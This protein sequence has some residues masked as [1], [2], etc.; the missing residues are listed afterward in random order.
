MMVSY[1]NVFC[2]YQIILILSAIKINLIFN[3]L[4]FFC[5]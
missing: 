2:E 3:W 1:R 5:D 4:V